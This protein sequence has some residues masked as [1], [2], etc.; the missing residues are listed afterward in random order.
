MYVIVHT[1]L[2]K[3]LFPSYLLLRLPAEVEQLEVWLRGWQRGKK[4]FAVRSA[5]VDK[6]SVDQRQLAICTQPLDNLKKKKTKKKE[7]GVMVSSCP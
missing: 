4:G 3:I 7:S 5:V 1:S 2:S 6:N